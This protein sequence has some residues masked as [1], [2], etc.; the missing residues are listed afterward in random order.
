MW[1]TRAALIL[2]L[3]LAATGV[4]RA[5]PRSS[6]THVATPAFVLAAARQPA[7]VQVPPPLARTQLAPQDELWNTARRFYARRGSA[8]AWF[9][10]GG[11]NQRYD[12]LIRALAK[13]E[14]HGLDR[15]AYGWTAL[16]AMR[17]QAVVA[18]KAKSLGR[19]LD[20]ALLSYASHLFYGRVDP[21]QIRP[22]WESRRRPRDLAA[23]LN[24]ALARNRLE[25]ALEDLAPSQPGYRALSA[26]LVRYREIAARGGWALVPEPTPGRRISGTERELLAR[27]L[28]AEGD[29]D[30]TNWR[31]TGTDADLAEALR[32]F[33]HRHGL[34]DH[35]ALDARTLGAL[36]VTAVERVRQLEL[37]LERW[38]WLPDTF[39][40]RYLLVN[41]PAFRLQAIEDGRA[42]LEMRAVVGKLAEPTPVLSDEMTQVVFSPFWNVPERIAREEVLPALRE[43]PDYLESQNLQLLRTSTSGSRR[44][45]LERGRMK[46]WA[47]RQRPGT[48]NVMGDVKFALPNRFDV[49]L[50]DTPDTASFYAE[51]PMF[52]HGCVRVER[53][54]TLAQYVLSR[55]SWWTAERIRA[56]MSSGRERA[57]PLQAPLPVHIVYW[58]AWVGE[59]GAVHFRDDAY[60]YDAAQARALLAETSGAVQPAVPRE[61]TPVAPALVRSSRR[62]PPRVEVAQAPL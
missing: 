44:F 38:R 37:N 34:R 48:G 62:Q 31:L 21:R 22:D 45:D 41:I 28:D 57:V 43:D 10:G 42:R 6:G 56:A 27:R 5:R 59:D 16:L 30:G 4:S 24:D 49:Y 58:T 23:F 36:N 61:P 35:G 53:P 29:L 46:G 13:A 19:E 55:Q 50:H 7:T 25:P 52:S 18:T 17:S 12:A 51:Q 60:G 20:H 40:S 14:S 26:A 54:E 47:F 15:E 9:N 39:G 32:R 3:A 33:Q 11:P 1:R 8:P 2:V